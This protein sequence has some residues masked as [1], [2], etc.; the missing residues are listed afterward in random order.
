MTLSEL[1]QANEQVKKQSQRIRELVESADEF[2]Q[3][4]DQMVVHEAVQSDLLEN[5]KTELAAAKTNSETLLDVNLQLY[6]QVDQ[7]QEKLK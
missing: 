5:T 4:F 7:L 1:D 6:D 2:A 3:M